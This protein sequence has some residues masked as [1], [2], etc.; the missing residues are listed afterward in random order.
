MTSTGEMVFPVAGANMGKLTDE[1]A[2][3]D[4]TPEVAE[5]PLVCGYPRKPWE[6][7]AGY[8]R[9]CPGRYP[10]STAG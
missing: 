10:Q 6:N 3:I 9:L 4:D 1:A 5:S 7:F 2:R 8:P